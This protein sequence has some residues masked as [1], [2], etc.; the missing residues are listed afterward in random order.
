MNW[1]EFL[2]PDIWKVVLTIIFLIISFSGTSM[3]GCRD[4]AYGGTCVFYRGFP[5]PMVFYDSTLYIST[6]ALLIQN[7]FAPIADLIFWYIISAIIA[8]IIVQRKTKKKRG[9]KT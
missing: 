7:I 4:S 9:R 8:T 2:K 1:K 5:L 3:R 6:Q